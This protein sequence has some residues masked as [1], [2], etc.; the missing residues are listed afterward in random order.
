MP[1]AI[2]IIDVNAFRK[3][4]K[5]V[6]YLLLILTIFLSFEVMILRSTRDQLQNLRL[7]L[8]L[9]SVDELMT[10]ETNCHTDLCYA[11]KKG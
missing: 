6:V 10:K 1:K 4:I 3:I 2:N 5:G 11:I 9:H 8:I 7:A